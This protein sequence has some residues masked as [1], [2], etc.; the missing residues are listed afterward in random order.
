MTAVTSFEN[1]ISDTGL[2]G[3]NDHGGGWRGGGAG[4]YI[5][6]E[7]EAGCCSLVLI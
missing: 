3:G 5:R 4:K 1:T 2:L 6:G 7:C